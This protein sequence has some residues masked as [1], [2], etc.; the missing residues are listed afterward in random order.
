MTVETIP[1]DTSLV[2]AEEPFSIRVSDL[3]AWPDQ[4]LLVSFD[5]NEKADR[6]LWDLDHEVMGTVVAR[7]PV[8][9]GVRYKIPPYMM[10]RFK[11]VKGTEDRVRTSNLG[12]RVKLCVYPGPLGGSFLPEAGVSEARERRLLRRDWWAPVG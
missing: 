8:N 2:A 6:W 12:D 7:S 3:T 4:E 5:Y 11:D 9:L 1:I 10:C